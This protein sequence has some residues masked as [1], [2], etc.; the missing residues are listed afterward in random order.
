MKTSNET[1]ELW[2]ALFLAKQKFVKAARDKQNS[3]LKNRY[4]TLDSMLDA[5][6]PALEENGIMVIQ[7][8]TPE[9]TPDS[10][11]L[12]TILMHKSGQSA[13]FCMMMPI[14]KRDPQGVGSAMTY[15]RRYSLAAAL[16]I[17]QA[18]DDAQLA[19]KS[20]Q[21][22]K[23]EIDKCESEEELSKLGRNLGTCDEA[24]KTIVRDHFAKKMA[25]I[26]AKNASGFN[27]ANPK[28]RTQRQEI[29]PDAEKQKVDDDKQA[30]VQ[31]TDISDF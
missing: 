15:A 12:E 27:P 7:S 6:E 16:G 11:Q 2:P 30:D 31:S 28:A 18:D 17:S 22:W 26:K 1:N 24:V 23:K 20:A 9:S 13:T 5:V 8:M 10:I 19:V 29:K 4:A 14:V 3:H 21:D 25:E